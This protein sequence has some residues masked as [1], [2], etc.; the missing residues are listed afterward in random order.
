MALSVLYLLILKGHPKTASLYPVQTDEAKITTEKNGEAGS[1]SAG[2]P[3]T[4]QASPS[5]GEAKTEPS[6]KGKRY[7]YGSNSI[8][9]PR[10][11]MEMTT[12]MK[13]GMIEDWDLFENRFVIVWFRGSHVGN[14]L[15]PCHKFII[16]TWRV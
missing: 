1:A 2:G 12:M 10:E 3:P 9:C 8:C 7:L 11:G 5:K 15:F 13:D 6:T 4:P 14:F 16:S